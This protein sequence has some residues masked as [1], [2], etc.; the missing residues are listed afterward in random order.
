[1][2]LRLTSRARLGLALGLLAAFALNF[3]VIA[4]AAVAVLVVV[5]F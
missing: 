5:L 3:V 2:T 4:A 1:M